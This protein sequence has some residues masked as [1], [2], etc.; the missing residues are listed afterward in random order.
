MAKRVITAIIGLPVV[1]F[2]VIFGGWPLALMCL[3]ASLMGLRELYRAFS[4]VDKAVHVI[5]YIAA[6]GYFIAIFV[7]GA[8]Q[9]LFIALALFIVFAQ[10]CLVLFFNQLELEDVIVTIYGLL[11]VPFLLGFIL[12]VREFALGQYFVWLIFT[13]AFGCDTFAYL[14]G[15]TI[16]RR[17]LVGS[18]SP[19]KSVEGLIGGVL[20][21]ALVG[22][23][24][25]FFIMHFRD[26]G[27]EGFILICVIV[28]LI[29]AIFC[30]FG[31]LAAS[32]IKRRKDIKD[33]SSLLPGHG[34]V[35]DRVDGVL[36]VAP[37]V[38]LAVYVM[39]HAGIIA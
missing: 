32:A 37:V 6:I 36:F 31:D 38:Y 22:F 14:T 15:V 25:G 11:Y 27:V 17:K 3:V 28:S 19:S 16:G 21:A 1:I 10:A 20:G 34:G 7:F 5:G 30:I 26:P 23:V 39:Y 4:K 18:P 9:W 12:L 8:C 35:M 24:Y 2:I 29:G 33:F 13:A